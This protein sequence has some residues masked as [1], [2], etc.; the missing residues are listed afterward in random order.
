MILSPMTILY[1][2]LQMDQLGGVA[3]I[4][5]DKVNWLAQHGYDVVVC[6]IED[7]PMTPY[8]PLDSRVSFIIGHL[9]TTPGGILTRA[10]NV[11]RSLRKVRRIIADVKPDVIINAHCPL[12]T[13][14]LP[15]A[16]RSLPLVTE[17]HQSR[18]GLAV[19]NRW[20]MSRPTAW[21]HK[22]LIRWIYGRYDRF[23]TLT[24]ADRQSWHLSNCI[25][26]PNFS[27]IDAVSHP[28]AEHR[29]IIMLARLMPQKRIDLMIRVWQKLA[30]RF[31][32]WRV[33]VLGEG[34][35]RERLQTLIDS[36]GLSGSFLLAGAVKDV[37]DELSASDIMCLTSEYEGFGIVLIEAMNM[38]VPVMAMDYVG[39]SDIIHDGTDGYVVPFADVDAYADRLATLMSSVAERRRL[40]SNAYQSVRRFDRDTVMQQW[41]SLF[42]EL[43]R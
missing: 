33:K 26:I 11:W 43:T 27:S 12:V 40:A 34:L 29:Q 37:R 8:Y 39:V 41:V 15:F 5:S 42:E 22:H 16:A 32:Q 3:R 7:W 13:W 9:P 20:A 14:I 38:G 23:V 24:D 31:P 4:E 17:M 19:F 6:D 25:C 10:H 28:D 21:A 2:T 1:F 36:A 18:Q 35:E 30:P